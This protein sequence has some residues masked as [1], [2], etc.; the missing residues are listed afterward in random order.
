MQSLRTKLSVSHIMIALV[1]IL[2]IS[3]LVNLLLDKQ[4]RQY[5]QSNLERQ[6]RAV[7]ASLGREYNRNTQQWSAEGVR[8]IGINALEQGLILHIKTND[9]R[10][11]WDA[12]QHNSGLCQEMIQHMANNMN[13]RYPNWKGQYMETGYPVFQGDD[14]IG[15][16]V[17]GYYGPLYFND[18]DL[19]FINTLNRILMG[20]TVLTIFLA[21]T[22]GG[23]MAKR[24]SLPIATV[25]NTARQIAGGNLA[26]RSPGRARVKEINQLN[27]AINDMAVSLEQQESLRKRLTAD[28]AHELRTPLAT[29]QSHLEALIDGVWQPEPKRFEVCHQEILRLSR[30]VAD[31]E[32][33]ARYEREVIDLQ[34][35]TL[36]LGGIAQQV[37]SNF[38]REFETKGVN[39][40]YY[41]TTAQVTGDR[42]KL[43]Q[44][45]INLLSNAL[46]FTPVAGT[47]TVKLKE[48]PGHAE[49]EVSDTGIGIAPA[50]VPF[51]FERFY[52]VDQ[53]RNR[54]TGGTG[55][56]LAIVRAIAEAHHGTVRVESKLGE[57][58]R[59]IVTIPNKR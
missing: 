43:S 2:M 30:M 7:V 4:F 19:A 21:L 57:G 12:T 18:H 25:I 55:I 54:L 22:I 11:V 42:D 45:L 14:L 9:G 29:L 8:Q 38:E 26:A 52:R 24:L 16:V 13:S 20:V 58:S 46:K 39:L 40:V 44:L 32:K 33:L 47:V 5:I 1:S 56:G 35:E 59:F 48:T 27:A 37:V 31:L 49:L 50:D 23:L 34:H 53:S 6:N 36:D 28:V 51:I 10:T 3:A 17:I 15:K 41:G